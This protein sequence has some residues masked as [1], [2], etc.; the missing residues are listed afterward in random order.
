MIRILLAIVM[1]T[2]AGCLSVLSFTPSAP[3]PAPLSDSVGQLYLEGEY[4]CSVVFIGGESALT[5]AHCI[6][7]GE[8]SVQFGDEMF[9]VHGVVRTDWQTFNGDIALLQLDRTPK[10]PALPLYPE[11]SSIFEY[12]QPLIVV[13]RFEDSL[14]QYLASSLF[15]PE[16]SDMIL[17]R[18]EEGPLRRGNSGGALIKMHE[19]KPHLYGILVLAFLD[20]ATFREPFLCG[21]TLVY[22]HPWIE[23]TLDNWRAGQEARED[24]QGKGARL[25]AL[26]N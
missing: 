10:V 12:G 24:S 16:G 13:A 3:T 9:E 17:W 1:C 18:Y 23:S 2:S 15:V 20:P 8:L 21:A 7:P 26:C 5:A 22:R 4:N 14:D 25:P 11:D 19:G 6:L